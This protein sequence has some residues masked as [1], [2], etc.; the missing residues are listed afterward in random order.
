MSGTPPGAAGSPAPEPCDDSEFITPGNWA[1]PALDAGNRARDV[2]S[3]AGFPLL[4]ANQ[5]PAPVTWGGQAWAGSA[6][7]APGAC[8]PRAGIPR[9]REAG[10]PPQP[11]SRNS[12]PPPPLRTAHSL[13]PPPPG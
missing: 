4:R 10:E 2:N 13:V 9:L 8:H 6:P 1:G 12:A 11:W 5:L 7:S 3:A